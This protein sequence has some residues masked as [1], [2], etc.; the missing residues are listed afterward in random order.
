MN[1]I[2]GKVLKSIDPPGYESRARTSIPWR[3]QCSYKRR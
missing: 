2:P 3:G 1:A